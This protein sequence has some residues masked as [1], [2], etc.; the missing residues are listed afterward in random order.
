MFG[1]CEPRI[2]YIYAN[3]LI[4]NEG[5]DV[6]VVND[7]WFSVFINEYFI[8]THHNV[9][10]WFG[11]CESKRLHFYFQTKP[12]YIY[13]YAKCINTYNEYFINLCAFWAQVSVIIFIL[14]YM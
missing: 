11:C 3:I 8:A 1:E 6:V 12:R 2:F 14:H 4:A 9:V 5:G 13:I 7:W 10:V